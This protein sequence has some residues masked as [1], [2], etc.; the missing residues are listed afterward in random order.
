MKKW[1]RSF[2]CVAFAAACVIGMGLSGQAEGAVSVSI[3]VTIAL[4]GS[5]PTQKETYSVY[6]AAEDTSNPM[7]AGSRNGGYTLTVTG[8][9][10]KKIPAISYDRVGVYRYT[11]SQT[12]GSSK[13]CAYDGRG[14][15]LTV[16]V[17]NAPWGGLETSAV[18]CREPDGAKTDSA[19]F[20][21]RYG[22][23]KKGIPSSIPKTADSAPVCLSFGTALGSTGMLA[24]L[25]L[26]RKRETR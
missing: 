2:L 22:D 17:G 11:L 6:L 15:T 21:N 13:K 7:P 8:A 20:L 26:R 12:A 4:S 3:P 23:G 14:Y 10:S 9:G 18:L 5:I 24:L 16:Q 25:A 1:W 19:Y